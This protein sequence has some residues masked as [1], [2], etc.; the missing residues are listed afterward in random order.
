MKPYIVPYIH[1]DKKVTNCLMKSYGLLALSKLC[2]FGGPFFIKMGI[3]SLSAVS[4]AIN[5]I[6]YFLGF[7]I[8]YT[9]SVFFEQKRNLTTSDII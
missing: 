3:N 8:C 5:P 4:A 6:F 9:G 7:G 2:F 1:H